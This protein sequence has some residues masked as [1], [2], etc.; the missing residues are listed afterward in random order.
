M[1]AGDPLFSGMMLIVNLVAVYFNPLTLFGQAGLAA[2][3]EVVNGAESGC[4]KQ[5]GTDGKAADEK[6]LDS[7]MKAHALV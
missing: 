3:P 1:R 7:K 6:L 5:N 2:A 4:R